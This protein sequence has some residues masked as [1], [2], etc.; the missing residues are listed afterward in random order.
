MPGLGVFVLDMFLFNMFMLVVLVCAMSGVVFGMFLG[1]VRGEFRPVG[2]ASGFDFRDFFFGEFRNRSDGLFLGARIRLFFIEFGSAD[3]SI[4]LRFF[5][6]FFMLGLCE[7]G[8]QR[9]DLIFVQ[10]RVISRGF[11]AVTSRFL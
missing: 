9:G 6:G 2:S 7:I 1:Y 11:D 5:G 10:L 3:D 4:G 8:G